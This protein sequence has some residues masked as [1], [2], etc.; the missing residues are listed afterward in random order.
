MNIAEFNLDMQSY[1]KININDY[2]NVVKV[3]S[4]YGGSSVP[5]V[6]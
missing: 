2:E 4:V 5:S 3:L 6:Q 1:T